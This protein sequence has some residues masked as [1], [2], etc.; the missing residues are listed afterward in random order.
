VDIPKLH[1]SYPF[2]KTFVEWIQASGWDKESER[3]ATAHDALSHSESP[4]RIE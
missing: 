3:G 4:M 2:L 1:A